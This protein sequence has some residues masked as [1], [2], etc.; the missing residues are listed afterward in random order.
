MDVPQFV[1]LIFKL[2]NEWLVFM[3]IYLDTFIVLQFQ[4]Q[5]VKFIHL[6]RLMINLSF[7]LLSIFFLLVAVVI[8]V[9]V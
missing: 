4:S 8:A 1:N 2:G 6:F 7:L 3:Y 5:I 9:V